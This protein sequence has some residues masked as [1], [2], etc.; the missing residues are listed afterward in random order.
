EPLQAANTKQRWQ[1]EGCVT[2]HKDSQDRR[3]HSLKFTK[4]AALRLRP[5]YYSLL[6]L[7]NPKGSQSLF[8]DDHDPLQSDFHSP[9]K[10]VLRF[11][12]LD[13]VQFV[14]KRWCDLPLFN[15]C[16]CVIF[17]IK[18][19]CDDRCDRR[20]SPGTKCFGQSSGF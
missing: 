13:R 12:V 2:S 16:K 20:C 3:Y 11:T 8:S 18:T 1:Q 6:S 15:S 7:R 5:E 10:L 4:S 14:Q 17:L 19:Y 9:A